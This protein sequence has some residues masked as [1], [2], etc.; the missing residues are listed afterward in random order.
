MGMFDRS[1][2]DNR[3][4]DYTVISLLYCSGDVW[5]GNV[6]QSYTYRGSSVVQVGLENTQA[7]LDW[8][9]KQQANGGL[10]DVL[11]DLILTGTSA[12]SLGVQIWATTVLESLKWKQASVLPDS[13]VGIFPDGTEGP[14]MYNFGICTWNKLPSVLSPSCLSQTLTMEESNQY[15]FKQ[16]PNVPFAFVQSKTD[17]VQQSFYVSVAISMN[18]SAYITPTIFYEDVNKVF[19]NYNKY[20]PNFLTYLV[21]GDQHGFVFQ[22]TY[23]SADGLGPRDNNS[24][25]NTGEVLYAW[26]NHF[27][28]AAGETIGTLCL[29]TTDDT[30]D[31]TYCSSQVVPKSYTEST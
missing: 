15:F 7:T 9:V 19:A 28:L 21:D 3:F 23:Y 26:S 24:P 22:N 5:G 31:N 1:R 27:P 11:S 30:G 2:S 6:T 10:S 18:V 25:E 16:Y 29:G 12:G 4:A 13:Y 20:N 14:I 17:I 8:I